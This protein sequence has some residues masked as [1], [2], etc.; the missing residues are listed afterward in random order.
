MSLVGTLQN[1]LGAEPAANL[2]RQHREHLDRHGDTARWRAVMAQLPQVESGWTMVD[3]RLVAGDPVADQHALRELLKTFVPWRKGPLRLGGV[4]I[5]T[6]WRSDLKWARIAGHLDL[7]GKRIL[8]VGAGNGYFGWCMLDAGAEQVIGCDPTQLFVIQH[9]VIG[10]FAGP[11]ANELLALRLEDLP[12]ALAGFDVV[13]SMGVLYHRRDHLAHLSDLAAR[14]APGGQLVLETLIVPGDEM[15]RLTPSG[16][17]ANMRNVHALPTLPQLMDWLD[18]AGFVELTCVD[19]T[20][21]T[22]AEQRRTEWMPF[23]SLPEALDPNDPAR[24]REGH[25]APLRAMLLARL[26]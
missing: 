22:R 16:R 1:W 2:L 8:D 10:H 26:P 4:A 5:D 18:Q 12:P 20:A 13:F 3:G 15:T 6:E 11:A 9:E 21:T 14:L 7:A 25:P 23:H 19:V 17:Y 24:T